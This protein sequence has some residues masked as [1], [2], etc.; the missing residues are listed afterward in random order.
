[1]MMMMM[2]MM[3]MATSAT[4]T[5]TKMTTATVVTMATATTTTGKT[6]TVAMMMMMMMMMAM[7]AMMM[8]MATMATSAAA[9]VTLGVNYG[10]VADNLPAPADVAKLIASVSVRKTRLYDA[11]A[12][13]LSAFAGTGV[14]FVVGTL[15]S[16]LAALAD[17]GSGAAHAAQWVEANVRAF[18]PGTDIVGVVVGNEI[19][20][21]TASQST[22]ALVLPAMRNVYAALAAAGLGSRVFVSTAHSFS[23]LSVSYP[24]SAGAFE[25]SLAD[26]YMAPV[27]A[28][29]AA[30]GAPFM[31]N[32]Y[33]FFAYKDDPGAVPL[34]Y[35]L[36]EPNATAVVDAGTGLAYANMFDAQVDAV[37]SA[38]A[39]LGF[40]DNVTL[41]VSETG[42]PSAGDADEPGAGPG[43]AR[44]Y[45]ANLVA[46]AASG[47]GTPLRPGRTPDIYLFALFNENL[48][49]G[50]LSERHYGLFWPNGSKVYDFSF[51]ANSSPSTPSS[52]DSPPTTTTTTTTT[53]CFCLLL[54]IHL[55]ALAF[56]HAVSPDSPDLVARLQRLT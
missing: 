32:V 52:N 50:P 26:A 38:I 17:E 42:W 35:V 18:Y 31:V 3:M 39:R 45:H 44:A 24:P 46:H 6:T 10:Q 23:T 19:F 12:S 56:W 14:T 16:E 29:L 51:D 4:A 2:M 8:A 47:A 37:Y 28:F 49:P 15:N 25:P 22:M 11:N 7:M 13:V 53:A 20:S 9:K 41:L 36:F 55:L 54:L 30:T 33:P 40:V 21:A 43:N 48:K 1:M 34:G 27:I 5:V